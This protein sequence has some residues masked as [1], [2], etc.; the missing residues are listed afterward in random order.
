MDDQYKFL[1]TAKYRKLRGQGVGALDAFR[2]ANYHVQERLRWSLMGWPDDKKLMHAIRNGE[3]FEIAGHSLTVEFAQDTDREPG[4][5]I[6]RLSYRERRQRKGFLK[7]SSY[8]IFSP[9]TDRAEFIVLDVSEQDLF[10]ELCRTT[11][12][13]KARCRDIAMRNRMNLVGQACSEIA[14]NSMPA[15]VG[16][17]SPTIDEHIPG[18]TVSDWYDDDEVL[19]TVKEV[20]RSWF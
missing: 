6:D 17:A 19:E 10:E 5:R 18:A 1:L 4:W 7:T 16:L 11:K 13:G 2:A 8:R 12:Y 3:R 15:Y 14:G 20:I 9:V